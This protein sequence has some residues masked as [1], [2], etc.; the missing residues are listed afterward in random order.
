MKIMTFFL[1]GERYAVELSTVAA[2]VR[3]PGGGGDAGGQES[4]GA[5]VELARLLG[6]SDSAAGEG[7]VLVLG[8]GTG[9]QLEARV[10]RLGEV[11]E[12]ADGAVRAVPRYFGNPLLRGVVEVEGGLAVLLDA[13][14]LL[15]AAD[16]GARAVDARH[17]ALEKRA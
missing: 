12:V 16:P 8:G 3:P 5:P 2:V 4:T 15:H 1:S 14:G 7:P 11:L 9:R 17:D 6:I 10:E 13:A